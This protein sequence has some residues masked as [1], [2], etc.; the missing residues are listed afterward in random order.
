MKTCTERLHQNQQIQMSLGEKFIPNITSFYSVSLALVS[1]FCAA[2]AIVLLSVWVAGLETNG[3][4]SAS[5]WA[6]GFIFLGL[7][8]DNHEPKAFLQLV[9][10]I[11][12]LVLAWFGSYVS[13]EFVI[14]SGFLLAGWVAASL[15]KHLR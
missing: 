2:T 13:P 5:I 15:F 10:G 3:P 9:T 1:A 14:V 7:A 11:A 6:V 4:V 8:V 12:L